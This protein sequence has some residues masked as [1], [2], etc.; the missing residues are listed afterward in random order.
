MLLAPEW[1]LGFFLHSDAL[2]AMGRLPLQLTALMIVFDATAIVLGQALLG[3]GANRVVMTVTLALQWLVFL[4]IAWWTGVILEYG[5]IGIWWTQLGYR[6]L[7]SLCFAL[8]WQR[9]HWQRLTV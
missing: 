5:L 3:A 7:T 6:C 1:V 4:P 9:R 2:I 8:I